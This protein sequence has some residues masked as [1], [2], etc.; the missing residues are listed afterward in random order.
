M[1]IGEKNTD[2]IRLMPFLTEIGRFHWSQGEKVAHFTWFGE[3][4]SYVLL[5]WSSFLW[6]R[7]WNCL[8]QPLFSWFS[9]VDHRTKKCIMLSDFISSFNSMAVF[10]SIAHMYF[11]LAISFH[12]FLHWRQSHE[13]D[14]KIYI[15]FINISHI[16]IYYMTTIVVI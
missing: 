5:L 13:N 3:P 8:I 2:L 6:V 9:S 1:I 14:N 4:W 7:S 16:Y 15:H 10:C 12:F 11:L